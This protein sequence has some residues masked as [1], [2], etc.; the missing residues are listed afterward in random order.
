MTELEKIRGWDIWFN[1]VCILGQIT[2]AGQL[3]FIDTINYDQILWDK[4]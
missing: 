1:P 4:R 3:I 2:E